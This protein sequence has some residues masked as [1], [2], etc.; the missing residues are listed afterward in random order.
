[1]EERDLPT[2]TENINR[3]SSLSAYKSVNRLLF[4]ERAL[5]ID[6]GKMIKT[7]WSDN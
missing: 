3:I 4:I 5:W 2:Y 7:Q 1:M 6:Q